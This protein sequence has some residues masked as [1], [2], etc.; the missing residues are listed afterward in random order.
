MTLGGWVIEGL[1]GANQRM[2]SATALQ[3]RVFD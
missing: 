3:V 1:E 2:D